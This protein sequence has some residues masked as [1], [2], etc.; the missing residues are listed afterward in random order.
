MN[1]W[2]AE[3]KATIPDDGISRVPGEGEQA[4]VVRIGDKVRIVGLPEVSDWTREQKDFSLSVFE[5]LVGK[6]KK[7]AGFNDLGMAEIEFR[8]KEG[9]EWVYHTVWLEPYLLRLKQARGRP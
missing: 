7:I 5:Y 9:G 3:K 8:R 1:R 6:T 4:T 2:V